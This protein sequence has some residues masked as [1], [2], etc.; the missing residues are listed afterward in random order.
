MSIS[1]TVDLSKLDATHSLMVS[2]AEQGNESAVVATLASVL[3]RMPSLD[4]PKNDPNYW[5]TVIRNLNE[6]SDTI[7]ERELRGDMLCG[8]LDSEEL[9]W[10]EDEDA[11]EDSEYD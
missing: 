11:G 3:S 7:A 9:S 1:P 4:N 5:L 10:Q 2:M 8:D 6:L